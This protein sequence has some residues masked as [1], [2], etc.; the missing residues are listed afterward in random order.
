MVRLLRYHAVRVSHVYDMDFLNITEWNV[1]LLFFVLIRSS[2][3][4]DNEIYIPGFTFDCV[5]ENN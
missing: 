5:L 4:M 3:T 1:L 2:D